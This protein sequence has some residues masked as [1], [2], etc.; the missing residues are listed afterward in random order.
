MEQGRR[1]PVT[2][3]VDELVAVIRKHN[4]ECAPGVPTVS[5]TVPPYQIAYLA[6]FVQLDGRRRSSL[7]DSDL[8]TGRA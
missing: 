5:I 6:M 8:C 3:I 7:L 4:G 1:I 2:E